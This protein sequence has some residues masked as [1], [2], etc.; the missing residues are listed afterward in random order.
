MKERIKAVQDIHE[1][2]TRLENIQEGQELLAD[3]KTNGKLRLT[4]SV[5]LQLFYF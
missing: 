4:K 3:P 5:N 1:G 2:W